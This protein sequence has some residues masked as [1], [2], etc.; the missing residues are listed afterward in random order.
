MIRYLNMSTDTP[1][2]H[3]VDFTAVC[4]QQGIHCTAQRREIWDYF[5]SKTRGYTIADAIE[6][7]AARGIGRATIYRTVELFERLR[8]LTIV[9]DG[10]GKPRYGAVCPGHAHALVCRNCH[11]VVEFDDCDLTML[12]KLLSA[13]TGFAIQGH[14]LEI[15]GTCPTCTTHPAS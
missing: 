12:E 5:A 9:H 11:A 3:A 6:A 7:L 8:L 15:Y 10:A 14:H 4:R 13:K 2:R 1:H